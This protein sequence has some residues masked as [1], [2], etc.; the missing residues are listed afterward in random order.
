[1]AIGVEGGWAFDGFPKGFVCQSTNISSI[2]D[3][4]VFADDYLSSSDPQCLATHL[5]E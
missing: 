4:I 2:L 1:M 5:I 3:A